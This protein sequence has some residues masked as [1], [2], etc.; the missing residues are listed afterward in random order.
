MRINL[1]LSYISQLAASIR[2]FVFLALG[3]GRQKDTII[4]WQIESGW[5]GGDFHGAPWSMNYFIAGGGF[6][7][8]CELL[9]ASVTRTISS[10]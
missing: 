7:S 3:D 10:R 8:G 5:V 1:Q 2:I 4:N 6:T 9:S